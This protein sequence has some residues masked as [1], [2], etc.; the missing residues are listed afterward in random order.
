MGHIIQGQF[1]GSFSAFGETFY[2]ERAER[3]F[4]EGTFKF[5]SIIFPASSAEFD[6]SRVQW[7]TLRFKD[8]YRDSFI[9]VS[10]S[11]KRYGVCLKFFFIA[12]RIKGWWD[13]VFSLR[14]PISDTT[15]IEVSPEKVEY[16]QL[17]T[18]KKKR[19]IKFP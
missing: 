9:Q 15:D 4:D 11:D 8:L 19:G 14:Y 1:D 2:L 17:V 3:H 6:F 7:E 13:I 16:L 5:H 10:I 12:K 18:G